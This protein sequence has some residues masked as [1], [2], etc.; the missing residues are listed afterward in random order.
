MEEEFEIKIRFKSSF[1]PNNWREK[2]VFVYFFKLYMA[3]TISK[4]TSKCFHA[5]YAFK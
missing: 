1:I 3:E 5:N 2:H 4:L